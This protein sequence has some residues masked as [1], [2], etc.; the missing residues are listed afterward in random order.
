MSNFDIIIK[1][2]TIYDGTGNDSFVSD[3]FIKNGK[4]IKTGTAELAKEL[5]VKGYEW[6]K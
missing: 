3:V 1:N 5:E 4:I 6:L 2:G